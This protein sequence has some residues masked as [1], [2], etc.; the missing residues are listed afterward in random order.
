MLSA[1]LRNLRFQVGEA[2]L[3]PISHLH[4]LG[5]EHTRGALETRSWGCTGPSRRVTRRERGGRNLTGLPPPVQ[6]SSADPGGTGD[7]RG[8]PSLLTQALPVGNGVQN[9]GPSLAC[10]APPDTAPPGA[11]HLGRA[12][13]PLS[14]AFLP[15]HRDWFPLVRKNRC[16]SRSW[17]QKQR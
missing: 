16:L 6:G 5:P 14:P 10:S 4:S 8:L 15:Y 12:H 13:L 1:T 11:P 2:T 3:T 7:R 9:G 17:K